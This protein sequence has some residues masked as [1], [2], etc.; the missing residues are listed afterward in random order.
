MEDEYKAKQ[1]DLQE[2]TIYIDCFSISEGN[3]A[4][5]ILIGPGG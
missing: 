2:G 3:G 5:I 4:G 1:K